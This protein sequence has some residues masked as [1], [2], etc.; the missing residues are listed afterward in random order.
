MKTVPLFLITLL[1]TVSLLLPNAPAQNYITW[2]L[3]DGAVARLGKGS[4]TGNVAFSPDGT[5]LAVASSIGIWIYDARP[6]KEKELDLIIGH[7][8]EVTALA[9]SPDGATIASAN[10][11][12]TLYLWNAVTGEKLFTLEGHKGGVRLYCVFS[13]WKNNR[14]WELGY[15]RTNCPVVGYSNRQKQNNIQ[16]TYE[17]YYISRFFT[18][19]K[20]TRY[21]KQRQNGA[22][23]GYTNRKTQVYTQR[24]SLSL[25][26]SVAYST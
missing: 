12:G 10:W 13:R 16:R 4:I 14:K 1:L 11:D 25:S 22:I 15:K 23:V 6:G 5:R 9:F 18:R 3:P 7:T 2:S 26:S 8:G 19:W 17:G 24:T 21:G 20:H